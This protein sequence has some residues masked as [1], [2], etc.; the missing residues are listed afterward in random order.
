MN[1]PWL[2][3]VL[4]AAASLLGIARSLRGTQ[5]ALRI[6]LQLALAPALFLC[7]FPP[8]TSA[9]PASADLV[10][11]TP[12][13]SA[14][15]VAAAQGKVIALPGVDAPRAIERAPDLA[16]ALRRHDARSV[17]VVGGG[18]PPRDLDAARGHVTGFDAAPLPAGI[19]QLEAP[20]R[21]AA[22]SL[23]TLR[24]RVEGLAQGR[25]ELRDPAGTV[26]AGAA[27][28]A[29]GR[30]ALSATAKGAGHARFELRALA[31]DGT[32]VD[33]IDIPLVAG[34]GTALRVLVLAGGPDPQLK[35][36]RRWAVDAGLALD[37]RIGLSEGVALVQGDL[38]F[39]AAALA[40]LDLVIV[41]ER[42]W[43]S[44][45]AA[46][47][48]ALRDAIAGGLGLLL[49]AGGAIP[50]EVERDWA[51]L[52]LAVQDETATHAVS[53]DQVLGLADA[54]LS[55]A[56]LP[57]AM[58]AAAAPLLRADDGAL[59]GAWRGFGRGR[60][61]I[62]RIIDDWRL[63]VA[64]HRAAHATLWSRLVST[65]ARAQGTPEP[66]AS[67]FMRVGERAMLCGLE[68][69][70]Q[71]IAGDGAPSSLTVVDDGAGV[72]CAAWWP[73]AEGWH[74]LQRGG[75][76]WPLF[77]HPADAGP[78]LAAAQAAR[79]TRALLGDGAASTSIAH[80]QAMPRWPLL[81]LVVCL[82][83]LLWWLERRMHGSQR[84]PRS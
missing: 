7:L 18:L 35:Y 56:P 39:D 58:P 60:V 59:L 47:K 25:V 23:W 36:L 38:G 31:R 73:R 22:G 13:A 53:L 21:V 11:L 14:A 63:V 46:R 40:R 2:I 44:L 16:T 19:V 72:R 43:A 50:P 45:D 48:A 68:S 57:L 30:F 42:A 71:V 33:A 34:E 17:R 78:A 1:T 79:D 62:L 61:G 55:F 24:G 6:V 4:I 3:A 83:A 82:A 32:Q 51:A 27:A 9:P 54:R 67:D 66:S 65:L 70:D 28:D 37:S 26:V 49:R 15:Q 77:V 81:V 10:V 12:G 52:G 84:Q 76:S 69:G 8:S 20:P 80:A 5:R 29:D 74:R 64:G 75:Q 41:D